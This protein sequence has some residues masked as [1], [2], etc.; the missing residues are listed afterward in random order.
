MAQLVA[1][2]HE[3]LSREG[4][5][6]PFAAAVATCLALA[7]SKTA[8]Y[9]TSN[10]YLHPD[11]GLKAAYLGTEMAMVPDFAEMNPLI[12]KYVGGLEYSIQ[13]VMAFI[14][15]ESVIE[16]AVGDVQQG[17]ATRLPLPDDSVPYI[18]TDP[19]YYAAVP[20]SDLSDLC[21]VWLRR[22]LYQAH[23][24]LLAGDLTPKD[25]E[26]IAYYVQPPERE[27]KDA[28][29]F[30]KKMEVALAES[31]RVLAPG[32]IAII[33]FAHKGTAGWKRC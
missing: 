21:Y 10:C 6:G 16:R 19:P 31:R 20:Y 27:K 3:R 11:F 13:N 28:V 7:V 8:I 1:S 17:S 15:R 2:V 26:V 32:G 22:A 18:A 23:P 14:E 29:F 5:D 24:Q 25:D 33:I 9:N 30:E 4:Q 12:P